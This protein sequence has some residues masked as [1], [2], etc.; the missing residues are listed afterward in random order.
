MIGAL[1]TISIEGT[2]YEDGDC[3]LVSFYVYDFDEDGVTEDNNI[4][5]THVQNLVVNRI[6]ISPLLVSSEIMYA[7]VI[8]MK[9]EQYVKFEYS[10][11]DGVLKLS[12]LEVE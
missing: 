3:L 9:F 8:T 5:Q 7:V 2:S 12:P 10:E 1:K 6:E 4:P 11:K